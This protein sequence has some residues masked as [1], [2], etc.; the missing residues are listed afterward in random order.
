MMTQESFDQ[1]IVGTGKPY[2]VPPENFDRDVVGTSKFYMLRCIIAMAHADG[3]VTEEEIAY[4]SALM[5]RLPLTD[6][7][8]SILENDLDEAQDIDDL[9]HR[10]DLDNI[11]A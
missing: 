9:P 3:I 6:E 2:V 10:E 5:N 1:N 11:S 4:A 8:R 7:Q